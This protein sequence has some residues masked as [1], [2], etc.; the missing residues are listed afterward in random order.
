MPGIPGIAAGTPCGAPAPGP[1]AL[2]QPP[3]A[4]VAPAGLATWAAAV[5]VW[6][7][8]KRPTN[9]AWLV[10]PET[11]PPRSTPGTPAAPAAPG[12]N[13]GNHPGFPAPAPMGGSAVA[14]GVAET[15]T[16]LISDIPAV[17]AG[18]MMAGL[19]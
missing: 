11:T 2:V 16:A 15:A 8:D 14:P 19:T 17:T 3:P 1:T 7:T 9:A 4:N 12:V 10:P 5:Q 18:S 6:G 13:R